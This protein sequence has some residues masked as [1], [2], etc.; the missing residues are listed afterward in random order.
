MEKEK[1][2]KICEICKQPMLLISFWEDTKK[3][4]EIWVCDCEK[5]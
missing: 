4:Q 2:P 5:K 1:T 3:V